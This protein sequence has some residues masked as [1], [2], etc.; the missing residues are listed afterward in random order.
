MKFY[1]ARVNSNK[2]ESQ[3]G[4]FKASV[5]RLDGN[6]NIDVNYVSPY[7]SVNNGGL[8]AIPPKDSEIIIGHD[9]HLNEYFYF[10]TIVSKSKLIPGVDDKRA[11]GV[12]PERL[13]Y[14]KDNF[15]SMISF[16]N[17]EG[18]GLKI[19]NYLNGTDS[20]LLKSVVLESTQGH[21]L[22]LSDNPN[23][24]QVSL[25]NK[26]Q[27]GITITGERNPIHAARCIDM[28]TLNSIK[29][30]S[31]QGSLDISIQDGKDLTIKNYSTGFN[32][33]PPS[34]PGGNVNIVSQSKDIN[35]YTESV[36]NPITGE[37]GRILIST[38][39]GVIQLKAGANGITIYSLGDIRLKSLGNIELDALNINMNALNSINL[40]SNGAL[41]FASNSGT[42]V[43]GPSFSL[44]TATSNISFANVG[45]YIWEPPAPN[46][47]PVIPGPL[48]T[49]IP[50]IGAYLN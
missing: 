4:V 30:H 36:R 24:D 25:K 29:I 14:N 42:R 11:D 33:L 46:P 40:N 6:P 32:A 22:E 34:V 43:D 3:S 31:T 8:M 48:T 19:H 7:Y 47:A 13:A 1:K 50:E 12:L 35:I 23:R 41:I 26:N 37:A 44:N 17:T 27:E 38:P 9:E 45:G 15:P 21:R 5:E 49:L 28:K 20:P 16:A 10:G 2:N 18:A 39:E